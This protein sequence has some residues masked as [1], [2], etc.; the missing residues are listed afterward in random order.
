DTP[1]TSGTTYAYHVMAVDNAGN[2]SASTQDVNVTTP[3]QLLF[4]DD[5]NRANEYLTWQANSGWWIESG[6]ARCSAEDPSTS[7]CFARRYIDSSRFKAV[8][9]VN[10]GYGGVSFW[11]SQVGSFTAKTNI[12]NPNTVSLLFGETTLASIGFDGNVPDRT[13]LT[14]EADNS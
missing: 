2:V 5:F 12:W 6:Q 7:T 10:E 4:K 8:V 14:V 11:Y 3:L 9:N 1:I 13:K